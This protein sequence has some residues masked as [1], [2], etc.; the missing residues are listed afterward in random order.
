MTE[1]VQW[2][3]HK[4]T[5]PKQKG[6]YRSTHNDNNKAKKKAHGPVTESIHGE[7]MLVIRGGKR[8]WEWR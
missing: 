5:T 1:P 3:K 2:M 7:R 8:R 6:S 4:Y